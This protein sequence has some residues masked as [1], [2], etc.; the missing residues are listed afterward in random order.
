MLTSDVSERDEL[1]RSSPARVP[2]RDTFRDKEQR[3]SQGIPD[4]GQTTGQAGG[5]SKDYKSRIQGEAVWVKRE[6]IMRLPPGISGH[7]RVLDLRP[8]QGQTV[9][10]QQGF[11]LC[12]SRKPHGNSIVIYRDT[13]QLNPTG[14]LSA[15]KLEL[16]QRG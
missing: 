1:L 7:Q 16:N 4:R 2:W 10:L 3:C 13:A 5:L 8:G 6:E 9:R 11:P 15:F 14:S 12:F